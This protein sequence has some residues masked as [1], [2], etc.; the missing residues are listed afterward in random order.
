MT[1]RNPS[2]DKWLSNF[3]PHR[4][5]M[6][7][8]PAWQAAPFPLYRMLMRLEV[9]H[10]RH[11]GYE[12][13]NLFVSFA[14]FQQCGVSRRQ[15]KALL[16]L[17]CALKLIEVVQ[18]AEMSRWDIRPPNA[19]RLTYLPAKGKKA[20]TDDWKSINQARADA[21]LAGYR[22]RERKSRQSNEETDLEEASA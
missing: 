17:G 10:L 11:G 21:A 18:D 3:V 14:Q 15:I 13:G 16:D 22:E 19:Y 6:L 8:S 1:A 9:E 5:E 7:V 4:L 12:N 20:P 2:R